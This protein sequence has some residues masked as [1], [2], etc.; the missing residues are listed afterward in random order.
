MTTRSRFRLTPIGLPVPFI[1]PRKAMDYS[2][3]AA[4]AKA[5][6]GNSCNSKSVLRHSNAA[7]RIV[8]HLSSQLLNT[9]ENEFARRRTML[10]SR[11][12]HSFTG[13]EYYRAH[14]AAP[15]MTGVCP[16]PKKPVAIP[17]RG[18]S[19]R[20]LRQRGS[21]MRKKLSQLANYRKTPPCKPH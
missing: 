21:V 7:A 18:F 2:L 20:F 14:S 5:A 19:N 1:P 3:A 6:A 17:S 16:F 8:L 12:F 10:Q 11:N 15:L 13:E 9:P 4:F